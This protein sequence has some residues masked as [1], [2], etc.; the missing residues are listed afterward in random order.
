MLYQA[1][2]FLCIIIERDIL[3]SLYIIKYKYKGIC[4]ILSVRF[5]TDNTDIFDKNNVC[6][7]CV[8]VKNTRNLSRKR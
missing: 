6:V 5:H 7:C 3:L 1:G 4:E 8:C 2:I